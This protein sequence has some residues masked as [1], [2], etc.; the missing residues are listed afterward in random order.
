[1]TTSVILFSATPES[2]APQRGVCW[3]AATEPVTLSDFDPLLRN[4]VNW[5]SQTPFGWH[6]KPDAPEITTSADSRWWGESDEGVVRT[7]KIARQAG[8][9]TLL[10]PHVWGRQ[11][12]GDISMDTEEKWALW[13][14]N[15]QRFILHY[16]R[17]AEGA[18]I[19][20]FCVGTEL[21]GTT[22]SREREW[23]A[24]IDTVRQV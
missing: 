2:I 10:K 16:A 5:I 11:W 21:E 14:E 7:A 4:H 20:A 13:F 17:L 23:R 3:V 18:E 22:L 9:K 1:M 12:S 6:R 19:E 15:Y 8:I 24:I